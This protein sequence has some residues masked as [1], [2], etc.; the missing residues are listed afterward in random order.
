ML[1]GNFTGF[2]SPDMMGWTRS[3]EL[4]FMVI[5]GGVAT[6]FHPVR[7]ELVIHEQNRLLSLVTELS[8]R[9]CPE[10]GVFERLQQKPYSLRIPSILC[11]YIYFAWKFEGVIQ[12]GSLRIRWNLERLERSGH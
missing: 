2:I 1:M 5:I 12:H 8:I 7:G 6:L 10:Q 4:N 9:Y 11:K 3:G